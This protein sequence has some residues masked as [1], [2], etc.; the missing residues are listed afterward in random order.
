MLTATARWMAAFKRNEQ[1]C[2]L[3]LLGNRGTGKTHLGN[4]AW[5]Y[6]FSH[7][8]IAPMWKETLYQPSKTYWPA[9]IEELRVRMGEGLGS[10]N[11]LDLFDWPVVF[12]DDLGAERDTTGFSAE[13]ANVLLGS[14]VGKWTI[15]TSNLNVE[16]LA[17]IDTRI[18]DRIVREPGNRFIEARTIPFSKR[19]PSDPS[20][21]SSGT[22]RSSK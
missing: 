11:F 22:G 18:A 19:K 10:R 1:P 4:E 14:R 8:R 21:S 5:R 2:W 17:G 7:P 16:Q 20:G 12:I 15:I 13:K 6:A 3:A 9:F